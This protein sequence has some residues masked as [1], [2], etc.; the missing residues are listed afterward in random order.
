MPIGFEVKNLSLQDAL[1]LAIHIEEEAQE[2]Y[3]AFAEMMG[4]NYKGDAGDFFTEMAG[5]EAKHASELTSKRNKLFKGV[6]RRID[7][8]KVW[9]VEAP[10]YG[11]PRAHMSPR[12]AMQL[13]L[14]SEIKAH[15]FF[16]DAAKKVS[17][18]G[19]KKLFE[20]LRDEELR[21][22]EMV[23]KRLELLP[24]DEGPDRDDDDIETPSL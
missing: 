7:P 24:K 21:H 16:R 15:E 4:A 8:A 22:Q 13:A 18:A 14:E 9:D 1:D 23:R 17:D 11:S 3:T 6:P 10:E 12:Q 20:E 2:R 5:N 19:V